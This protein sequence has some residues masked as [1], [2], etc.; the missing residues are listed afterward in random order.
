M[1][2]DIYA[3]KVSIKKFLEAFASKRFKKE[4]LRNLRE[5]NIQK[6]I[7]LKAKTFKINL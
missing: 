6:E 5:Q 7:F 4:I 2:S 1:S 3:R